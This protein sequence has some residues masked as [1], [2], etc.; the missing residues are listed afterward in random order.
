MVAATLFYV[1]TVAGIFVLRLRR[2]ALERPVRIF[3]YPLPP[4]LYLAGA[5]AFIGALLVYRPSFTWPGMALVALGIPVYVAAF[6]KVHPG[7]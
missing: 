1:L 3:A 5:L 6:R 7:R 2:P 4:I